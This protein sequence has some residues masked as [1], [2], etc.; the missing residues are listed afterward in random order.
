MIKN[1]LKKYRLK[2]KMTQK[3][4][5]KTIGV[6]QAYLSQLENGQRNM[7]MAVAVG[8]AQILEI[9]LDELIEKDDIVS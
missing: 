2:K 8:L 4:L 7:S 5:C 3:Q 9:G 6:S 1:N